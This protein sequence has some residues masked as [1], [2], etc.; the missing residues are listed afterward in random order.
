MS[1]R[2]K[3]K[4]VDVSIFYALNSETEKKNQFNIK[5]KYRALNII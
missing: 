3:E 5:M 2:K 1:L 4:N